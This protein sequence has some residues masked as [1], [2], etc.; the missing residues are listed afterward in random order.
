MREQG[1]KKRGQRIRKKGRKDGGRKA[2]DLGNDGRDQKSVLV[3]HLSNQAFSWLTFC[4]SH[5]TSLFIPP[6]PV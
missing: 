2:F 4:V 5:V 3:G 6:I 1:G